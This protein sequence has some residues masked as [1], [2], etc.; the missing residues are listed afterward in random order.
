MVKW[1]NVRVW[2]IENPRTTLKHEI[3]SST[4]NMLYAISKVYSPFFFMKNAIIGSTHLDM[5]TL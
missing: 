1:H 4:V 2:G 5:F 3:N